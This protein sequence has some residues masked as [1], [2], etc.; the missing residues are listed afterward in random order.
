MSEHS[1][2][3]PDLLAGRGLSPGGAGASGIMPEMGLVRARVFAIAR[4][5]ARHAARE[6]AAEEERTAREQS[7][8][9]LSV[10]IAEL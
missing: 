4:A 8:R 5:L 1:K 10:D 2:G 3:G 9:S 6:D 7:R